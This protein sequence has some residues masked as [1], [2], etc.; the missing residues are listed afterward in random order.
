MATKNRNNTVSAQFSG[1]DGIDLFAAH[2]GEPSTLNMENWQI[3]RDGS[4]KKRC[5]FRPLCNVSSNIDAIWSGTI[6]GNFYIFLFVS[7]L[8]KY[9][10]LSTESLSTVGAPNCTDKTSPRFFYL[11]GT[12]YL[13]V[14]N[15]IF[16]VTFTSIKKCEGYVPLIGKDWTNDII[17]EI[18]QPL[19]VLNRRGRFTYTV[20]SEP[21]IFFRVLYPVDTVDSVKVNGMR[22]SSDRYYYDGLFNSVNISDLSEGDKVEIAVSF[23]LSN[24]EEVSALLSTNSS[25]VFGGISNSRV[26]MWNNNGK[27][28]VHSTAFVSNTDIKE[29]KAVYS[30]SDGL[31]F[32]EGYDFTV[33]DGKNKIMGTQRHYDRLLFFTDGDVWMADSSACSCSGD[34]ICRSLRDHF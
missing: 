11:N 31:Y 23:R 7:G 1:F 17:G 32:P 33:G 9:F 16:E 6:D 20:S 27:P 29:S 10:N 13:A 34:S 18:Y 24:S 30:S 25:T 21:S 22:I 2:K 26:F 8:V 12:L 4:I 19:N 28:V 5:G 3:L 14:R 15:G